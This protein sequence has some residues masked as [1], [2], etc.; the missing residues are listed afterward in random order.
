MI[1]LSLLQRG[2]ILYA[3]CAPGSDLISSEFLGFLLPEFT[4]QSEARCSSRFCREAGSFSTW[5]ALG[6]SACLRDRCDEAR[7]RI[8]DSL[9]PAYRARGHVSTAEAGLQG[10]RRLSGCWLEVDRNIISRESRLGRYM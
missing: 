4:P 2:R 6:H 1:F 5:T 8:I 10:A 9:C 3:N 7:R